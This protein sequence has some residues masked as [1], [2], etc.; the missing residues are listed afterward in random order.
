MSFSFLFYSGVMVVLLVLLVW[1]L[2]SPRKRANASGSDIALFDDLGR[3][4]AIYLP[5]IRQ[6]LSQGDIVFLASRGSTALTNRVRKDRRRVV[7]AFMNALHG[8]VSRGC[9]GAGSRTRLAE[10]PI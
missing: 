3:R 9:N 1:A 7:L 6:A 5:L 8:D 10:R 4:H 2:R